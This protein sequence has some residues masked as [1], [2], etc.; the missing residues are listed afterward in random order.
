MYLRFLMQRAESLTLLR[1]TPL[2][3]YDVSFLVTDQ[4]LMEV[5]GPY[6]H[7]TCAS[8]SACRTKGPAGQR[9]LSS[10]WAVVTYLP[11]RGIELCRPA[12]PHLLGRPGQ[13]AL[14]GHPV[15]WHIQ[16]IYL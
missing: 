4:H 1:R 3:G 12:A 8:S 9:G 16:I 10:S 13:G 6:V 15:Y 11:I 2:E 5:G 7:P 14:L